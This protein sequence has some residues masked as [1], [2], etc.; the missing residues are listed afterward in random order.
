[1][2]TIFLAS[3]IAILGFCLGVESSNDDK[4]LGRRLS[5]SEAFKCGSE[6]Y[7]YTKNGDWIACCDTATGEITADGNL[8]DGA[9]YTG[10][11]Y[12]AFNTSSQTCSQCGIIPNSE[13]CCSDGKVGGDCCGG[14]AYDTSAQGCCPQ[15]GDGKGEVYPNSGY[16]CC[17]SYVCE[18][19]SGSSS[20][21]PEQED[22][23]DDASDDGNDDDREDG[24]DDDD[25][26]EAKELGYPR[27]H[28]ECC[29]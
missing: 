4:F 14:S 7:D 1:M 21:C 8:S 17:G 28:P 16:Q 27:L 13:K 19:P 24:N 11:N 3:G 20:C 12:A 15:E 26:E 18:V 5:D 2:V 22:D 10:S 6:T 29:P 25:S 9:N 23:Y